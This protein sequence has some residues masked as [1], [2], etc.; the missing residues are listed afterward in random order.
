ML[1]DGLEEFHLHVDPKVVA[2]LL[3]D[4]ARWPDPALFRMLPVRQPHTARKQPLSK[5]NWQDRATNNGAPKIEGNVAANTTLTESLGLRKSQRSNRTCCH[6]WG[7]DDARYQSSASE[8]NDP[9]YFTCIANM[10][11][12]P[13]PLKAFTD[14][15]PEVKAAL[16]YV[17]KLLY[18]F[19]PERRD[20]P[21]AAQAGP[22]L[23][24]A[25]T[26][27]ATVPGVIPMTAAMQRRAEQRWRE[28]A[29]KL[30]NPPGSYP[31]RAERDLLSYWC[32]RA[33]ES[34]FARPGA[35]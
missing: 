25:W 16:R 22:Y 13:T 35:F 1:R 34:F 5:A 27:A 26:N 19:W 28:I 10:V 3:R 17:A 32:L 14:A 9:R 7:N 18:G 12:F 6:I 8:V 20:D 2:N 15:V 11:L 21:T 33:P 4:T 30:R 24:D 23:P 31:A 29:A